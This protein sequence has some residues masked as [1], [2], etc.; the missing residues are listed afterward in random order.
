[1]VRGG[2]SKSFQDYLEFLRGFDFTGITRDLCYSRIVQIYVDL[3][4]GRNVMIVPFER[5][6][7]AQASELSRICDFLGVSRVDGTIGRHNPSSD[8]R[9]LER[10]RHLNSLQPN[11]FGSQQFSFVDP[12]KVVPYW[13]RAGLEV[14]DIARRAWELKD[15]VHKQAASTADEDAPPIEAEFPPP[16]RRW[17]EV[18]YAPSNRELAKDWGIDLAAMGY[19][20]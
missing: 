4:G 18:L 19:P 7:T 5:F 3:F 20:T 1:M 10:I 14:P 16:L 6:V 17:F 15:Q 13:K 8:L 12:Q 9:L 2:L 11:N